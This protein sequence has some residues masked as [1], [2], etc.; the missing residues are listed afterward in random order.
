[1]SRLLRIAQISEDALMLQCVDELY[2]SVLT[3]ADASLRSF[4]IPA[5]DTL[6]R[7][8]SIHRCNPAFVTPS[9]IDI[10][11][12]QREAASANPRFGGVS[13]APSAQGSTQAGPGGATA[14]DGHVGNQ[15]A[16]A[17]PG[18]KRTRQLHQALVTSAIFF[19]PSKRK[20]RSVTSPPDPA[21]TGHGAF[22]A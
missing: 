1:L 13:D 18:M 19:W 8:Y 3:N 12:L 5:A 7:F 2:F 11:P 20:Y 14:R 4:D 22:S 9:G 17:A 10:Q 21:R 16:P 6:P 15:A